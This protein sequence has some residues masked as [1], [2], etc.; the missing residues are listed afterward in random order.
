MC[1]LSNALLELIS[2]EIV[3]RGLRILQ[4]SLLDSFDEGTK[5][6]QKNATLYYEPVTQM[7]YR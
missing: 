2:A 1:N 6:G 4:Y 3:Q 7:L 5:H